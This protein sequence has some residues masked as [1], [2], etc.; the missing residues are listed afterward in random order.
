MLLKIRYLGKLKHVKSFL[1]FPLFYFTWE[2]QN[3]Q[4][5]SWI[6]KGWTVV[7]CDTVSVQ[8]ADRS[9][10]LCD[11]HGQSLLAESSEMAHS[12][13]APLYEEQPLSHPRADHCRS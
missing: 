5:G 8:G 6:L 11:A 3:P 2:I 1:V 7:L 4:S 13:E 9:V 10:G 12:P